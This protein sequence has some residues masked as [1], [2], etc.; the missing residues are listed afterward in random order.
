MLSALHLAAGH[1][2]RV[3]ALTFSPF[4]SDVLLVVGDSGFMVWRAPVGG[5]SPGSG[6][7]GAA[8]PGGDGAAGTE[9]RLVAVIES[10]F[11][12]DAFYTCGCW[13]PSRPGEL[14]GRLAG[15]LG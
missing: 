7:D 10:P 14:S 1:T 5:S 6:S 8:A 12:A 4:F 9:A 2:G 13:S 11:C 3:L 15:Q